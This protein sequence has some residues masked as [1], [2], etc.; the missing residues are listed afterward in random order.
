MFSKNT[1]KVENKMDHCAKAVAHAVTIETNKTL[2]VTLKNTFIID[3]K[4]FTVI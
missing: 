2:I 3:L 1:L 4:R